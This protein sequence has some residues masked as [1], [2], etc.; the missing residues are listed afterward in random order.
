M[1]PFVLVAALLTLSSPALAQP[2]PYNGHFYS[3]GGPPTFW[4]HAQAYAMSLGGYLVVINDAAEDDFV[5]SNFGWAS[6]GLWLGGSRDYTNEWHWVNGDPW[7]YT[8][9]AANPGDGNA[10]MMNYPGNPG[11]SGVMPFYYSLPYVIEHDA[12]PSP[13]QPIYNPVTG[14]WY[15]YVPTSATWPE[16]KEN[17]EHAGGHL[18]A[19]ND[20]SENDY[21]RDHF[22]M[23]SD[24]LWIGGSL[25]NGGWLWVN[26][27]PWSF[28]NWGPNQP[29]NWQG[30]EN[31]LYMYPNGVW[32]DTRSDTANPY[33]IEYETQPVVTK[34]VTWGAVKAL[35]R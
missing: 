2:I 35:Y 15:G 30:I 8:N 9:W 10:L 1:K 20:Q 22:A 25:V 13:P 18:V 19:I 24:G 3:F 6:S 32:N 26:G 23:W 33:V 31:V 28:T 16:A 14:H 34:P 21:V 4:P 17:A 12:W 7:E 29:N 27:E 5:V 11:W